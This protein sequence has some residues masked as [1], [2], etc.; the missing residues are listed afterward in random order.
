[1]STELEQ[2]ERRAE[3]S[4]VSNLVVEKFMVK[5]PIVASEG[6]TIQH[7]IESLKVHKINGVPVVND[8]KELK[9][10]ITQYDLLLQAGARKLTDPIM[11]NKNVR[12]LYPEATLKEALIL[13]HKYRF[14]QIPII[15]KHNNLIGVI[16]RIDL[17]W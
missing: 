15:D 17:L 8:S 2:L 14:K 11:Y 4:N 16:S 1:M 7:V 6:H 12:S 9:G 10:H 3:S 5:N 13:F